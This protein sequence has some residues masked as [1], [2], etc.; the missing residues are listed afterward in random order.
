MN[1]GSFGCARVANNGSSR[2][3]RSGWVDRSF[4]NFICC[5]A[6]F[7]QTSGYF[8][9]RTMVWVICVALPLQLRQAL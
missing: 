5:I 4:D 3:V 7:D 8:Y 6:L 2:P 1:A 9:S